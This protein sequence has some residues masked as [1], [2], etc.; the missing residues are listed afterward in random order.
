MSRFT[1]PFIFGFVALSLEMQKNILGK[2][3]CPNPMKISC[4]TAAKSVAVVYI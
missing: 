4:E 2:I 3:P 1:I